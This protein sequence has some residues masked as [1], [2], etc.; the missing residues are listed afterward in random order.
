KDVILQLNNARSH[1]ARTTL[2]KVNELGWKGLPRPSYSSNITLSD[3]NLFKLIQH[4]LNE[5]IIIIWMTS[6]M[7]SSVILPKNQL[8]YIDPALKICTLDGKRLLIIK[9]IIL[10]I[11]D[12]KFFKI[13]L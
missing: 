12:K 1:C 4:F 13:Y 11:K 6:K 3:F 8:I 5:K 9:V 10:L 2:E 7:P